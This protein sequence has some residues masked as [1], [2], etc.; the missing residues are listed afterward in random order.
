MALL[1]C[2]AY[3]II[4]NPLFLE[5]INNSKLFKE[6]FIMLVYEGLST[7]HELKLN[8]DY[9]ILKN[10]KAIGTLQMQMVRTKSTPVILEMDQDMYELEKEHLGK[11]NLKF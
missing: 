1:D 9:R 10:R 8:G 4:I 7:K 2:S 11:E 3:D 5:K 6:F